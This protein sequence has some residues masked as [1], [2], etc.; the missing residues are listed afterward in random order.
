MAINS[1]LGTEHEVMSLTDIEKV[2]AFSSLKGLQSNGSNRSC[3]SS[4]P[5]HMALVKRFLLNN[6][7]RLTTCDA[8]HVL[9]ILKVAT[10][11]HP[12]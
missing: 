1:I 4:T 8:E 7:I 11:L 10:H 12:K 2:C 5:K 3:L 6:D 9:L